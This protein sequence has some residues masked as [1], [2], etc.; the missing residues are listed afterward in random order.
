MLKKRKLLR[1]VVVYFESLSLFL[2]VSWGELPSN[3]IRPHEENT[4]S[5]EDEFPIQQCSGD[6]N[7]DTHNSVVKAKKIKRGPV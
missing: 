4:G 3:A 6:R 2:R 7:K 5:H 1:K